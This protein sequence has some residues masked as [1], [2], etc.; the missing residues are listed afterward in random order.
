MSSPRT[1]LSL[2]RPAATRPAELQARALRQT[3]IDRVIEKYGLEWVNLSK[4]EFVEVEVPG[5]RALPKIRLPEILLRTELITIPVMKTHNKTTIT[6]ALKNQWGCLPK[7]RH[8]YHRRSTPS[9]PT[10]TAP[11][12]RAWR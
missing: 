4:Q 8:R 3:R 6:G 1:R 11:C 10:S 9:S 2:T 7:D 5:A 12:S